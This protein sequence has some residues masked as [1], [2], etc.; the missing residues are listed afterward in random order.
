MSVWHVF[1]IYDGRIVLGGCAFLLLGVAGLRTGETWG[2]N[3]V[4]FRRE[5]SPYTFGFLVLTYISLGIIMVL[6]GILG[7]PFTK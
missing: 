3:G 6:V 7:S 4:W 5:E 1:G 2:K